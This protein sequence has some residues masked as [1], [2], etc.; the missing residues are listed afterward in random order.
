MR[1]YL[2]WLEVENSKK[3]VVAAAQVIPAGKPPTGT[4]PAAGVKPPSGTVPAKVKSP[5]QP[6][7]ARLAR[8]PE[9]NRSAKRHKKK[10]HSSPPTPNVAPPTA[11]PVAV[12]APINVEL[13]P[14]TPSSAETKTAR[15][16][17]LSRRDILLFG[18]GAC[19]GAAVT[20]VG[21][22]I[23]YVGRRE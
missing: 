18:I 11:A 6:D 10:R 4:M 20:F 12:P 22:V 17:G 1:S 3:P 19:A 8:H 15:G 7:K 14:L 13:V 9:R 2:T 5:K 16:V 21:A 23:A